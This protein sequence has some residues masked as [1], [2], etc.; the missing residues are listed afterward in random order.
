MREVGEMR[1]LQAAAWGTQRDEHSDQHQQAE[2]TQAS[3]GER[4]KPTAKAVRGGHSQN[5]G[6]HA[7]GEFSIPLA[8]TEGTLVA[9]YNRGMKLLRAAGGVRTTVHDDLE[10]AAPL[11]A[12][13]QRAALRGRFEHEH[14]EYHRRVRAGYLALA[15][16]EP[17]R[18]RL[19]DGAGTPDEVEA[20]VFAAVRDLPF[21]GEARP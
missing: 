17:E 15:S 14:V 3:A 18:F 6:E 13:L 16:A 12:G 4:E 20:R 11:P 10:R 7:E 19:V 2:N 5:E 21:P 8:T 9:S 1:P